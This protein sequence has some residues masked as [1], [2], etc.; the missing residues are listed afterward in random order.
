[1]KSPEIDVKTFAIFGVTASSTS[2]TFCT[3]AFKPTFLSEFLVSAS[4][5]GRRVCTQTHL[6]QSGPSANH[7]SLSHTHISDMEEGGGGRREARESG[8]RQAGSRR[9]SWLLLYPGSGIREHS[10]DRLGRKGEGG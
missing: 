10:E 3:D 9:R 8:A 6:A 2:S 4:S 7:V 5:C 1:M